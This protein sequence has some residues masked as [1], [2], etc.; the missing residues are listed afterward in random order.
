MGTATLDRADVAAPPAMVGRS[1]VLPLGC[2]ALGALVLAFLA[3]GRVSSGDPALVVLAA[4]L[5]CPV[6]AAVLLDRSPGDRVGTVL[7]VPALVPLVGALTAWPAVGS[8]PL[9]AEALTATAA[10]TVLLVAVVLVALPLLLGGDPL[11]GTAA[12]A[13]GAAGAA[14]LL[15]GVSAAL[16]AG[17]RP[18]VALQLPTA[19]AGAAALALLAGAVVAAHVVAMR[20]WTVSTGADRDRRG[21]ALVGAAVVAPSA[22]G[23]SG[24][25]VTG[26]PPVAHYATAALLLLVPVA[27][28]AVTGTPAPPAL[29]RALARAATFALLSVLLAVVYVSAVAGLAATGLP[30]GPQGAAVLTATAALVAIPLWGRCRELLQTR[31]FGAGRSPAQVLAA[32]EAQLSAQPADPLQ[33]IG[34]WVAAAVRSPGARVLREPPEAPDDPAALSVPLRAGDAL[35]G[36]LVVAP[37]RPGERFSGRDRRLLEQLAV[38]V[39]LVARTAAANEEL[40]RSE[41]RVTDERRRERRRVLDDL[42]DDL[43][44]ALSG[45]GMQLTAARGRLVDDTDAARRPLDA[46]PLLDSAV[47]ATEQARLTLRQL[48]RDLGTDSAPAEARAL[49]PSLVELTAGWSAAA[50]DTGLQ[51]HL[52]DVDGLPDLPPAVA[53]AAYRIAG[54]AVTNVVRH[55]R[56]TRCTVRAVVGSA[57]DGHTELELQIEDDGRSR[58]PWLPGVGLRSMD[59]RAAALGG[60]V[61][62]TAAVGGG[63]AVTARLPLPG[64]ADPP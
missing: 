26:G 64:P 51:V 33:A 52:A 6:A 30:D 22:A 40:A 8:R 34:A 21:W 15:S 11:Q 20:R 47:A 1:V 48:V 14:V 13:G 18:E 24:W 59:A 45:I 5:A 53:D 62:V 16:D 38:P 19:V 42:H 46:V 35:V 63:T 37:R 7:C 29:D 54:E 56:A 27:V 41:Q 3:G 58:E 50:A 28:L 61:T 10:P 55:A 36:H 39:A 4:C 44:P 43:G 25:I 17:L 12:L 23:L 32:L 49:G 60:T 9:P 31:L 2:F 57:D